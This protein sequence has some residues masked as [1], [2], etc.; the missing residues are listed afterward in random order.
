VMALAREANRYLNLKEPWQQIKAD[1]T[2]AATSIYVALR[3]IDSLKTLSAPFLPFT[4]QQLHE[5]LGYDGQL[6]GRLY[7]EEIAET[8]RKHIALRY[9]G[10]GACCSWAPSELAAGQAL[11]QPRPLYAKLEP[12]IVDE[13]IERMTAG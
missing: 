10:S 7:I 11:R 13:E 2:A 1:P 8:A 4:S 12:S 9:D 6:F 3:V 5:Y